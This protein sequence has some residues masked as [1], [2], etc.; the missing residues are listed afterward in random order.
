MMYDL[1]RALDRKRFAARVKLLWDKPFGEKKLMVE[2]K[3]VK[4]RRSLSTNNYMHLLFEIFAVET[5]HTPSE[6]KEDIFK[7]IV[8]KDIFMRTNERTGLASCR[9]SADLKQDE[10]NL[11]IERFR[12]WASKE[13]GIYLPL[14]NEDDLLRQAEEEVQRARAYFY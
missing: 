10:A 4:E 2:L 12:N 5:G 14:P 13:L 6:V 11:A 1:S 3:Q 8:N 9:S 7:R